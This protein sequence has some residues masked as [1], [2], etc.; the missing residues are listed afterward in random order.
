MINY[1]ILTLGK[2]NVRSGKKLNPDDKNSRNSACVDY[3]WRAF[4]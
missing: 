3:P 4:L 1:E 2:V